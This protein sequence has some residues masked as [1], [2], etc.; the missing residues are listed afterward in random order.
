MSFITRNAKTGKAYAPGYF[1]AHEE[2]VRVTVEASASNSAVVTQA[3]GSKYLP[4]GTVY[5]SND[6]Y[7]QGIIYEDVDVSSGNM[8]ASLVVAGRVFENRLPA[9]VQSSAKAVLTNFVLVNEPDV[10]RPEYPATLVE[11]TVTSA[12][13]TAVGDTAI[14]V[15]GYTNSADEGYV[16]KVGTAAVTVNAGDV[17]TGWTAWDGEDDITAATGKKITV[18]VVTG[19]N[20]AVAAGSA[21]VTAK[22]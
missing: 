10:T 3:D 1:L 18:A 13:G 11:L 17:L 4:M 14:T 19:A 20:E 5:P 7:A 21:T 6:G 12:A 22:A 2:C 9:D 16:Y 15:S 8:P